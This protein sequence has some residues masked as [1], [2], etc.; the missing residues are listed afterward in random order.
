M[1]YSSFSPLMEGVFTE[2]QC[3]G[4]VEGLWDALPAL[5]GWSPSLF[6]APFIDTGARDCKARR[7]TFTSGVPAASC[8]LHPMA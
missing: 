1:Q 6:R 3:C 7:V 2:A 4:V 5:T 8:F